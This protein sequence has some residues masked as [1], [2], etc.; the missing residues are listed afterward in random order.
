MA[1]RGEGGGALE[2]KIPVTLG[3]FNSL[4]SMSLGDF[5]THPKLC[6]SRSLSLSGPPSWISRL[7]NKTLKNREQHAFS[8]S[9]KNIEL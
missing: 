2:A 8:F 6:Y 4:L 3:V 7:F 5:I 1:D 9:K